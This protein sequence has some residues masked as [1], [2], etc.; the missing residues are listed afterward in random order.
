MKLKEKL[1]EK[2]ETERERVNRLLK[3]HGD[4]KVGD[5]T[6]AQVIGGMGV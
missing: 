3:E 4:V 5:I 6:I 1:K 2:I